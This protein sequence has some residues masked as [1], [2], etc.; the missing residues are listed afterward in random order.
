MGRSASTDSPPVTFVVYTRRPPSGLLSA[1]LIRRGHSVLERGFSAVMH[2][3]MHDLRPDLLIVCVDP[4]DPDDL[5][6]L[7]HVRLAAPEASLL[8]VTPSL[9]EEPVLAAF[10][11]GVDAC[12]PADCSA[13]IIA[14]QADSLIRQRQQFAT[15]AQ[16]SVV[17]VRDVVIDFDRRRVTRAGQPIE[18]TRTEFDILGVL[19]RN[20]GRVVSASEILGNIGQF[21]ASEAQ[22]RVIVKVHISHLRQKLDVPGAPPYVETIRG[23]GYLLERRETTNGPT[24]EEV[25]DGAF[26]AD[27]A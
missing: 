19:A 2:E 4:A 21:V 13:E 8:M 6:A 22:A 24:A 7:H 9:A 16:A 1:A 14:A 26:Q 25:D 3:L 18:L 20:P 5:S 15:P 23:V 27:T 12:L 17:Q 11:L 10:N